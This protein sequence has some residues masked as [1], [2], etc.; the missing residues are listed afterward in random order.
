M[1]PV[2]NVDKPTIMNELISTQRIHRRFSPSPLL[3]KKSPRTLNRGIRIYPG[4]SKGVVYRIS[5]IPVGQVPTPQ[6]G[7]LWKR[8]SLV[9]AG[10]SILTLGGLLFVSFLG[11][12][13]KTAPVKDPLE[14]RAMETY[15]GLGPTANV[16]PDQGDKIPLDL[17][18]TF[19][20]ENY[21]VRKGE[22]ISSIASAHG[23]SLDA[24][25]AL[26]GISNVKN[27]RAGQ[28]IRIP[29]MDGIPYTIKK[30][31]SLFRIS[32]MSGIPLNAI[33]DANDLQSDVL[34]VGMTV[35]L[36]GARMRSDELKRALGQLFIY[37]VRGPLSSL[38][39]W[40]NDPFTGVRRFH[41]AIDIAVPTG[42]PVKAALDGKVSSEGYNGTYGN[43]II[44]SH[45]GG[46]QTL[47]AHLSAF[48][49]PKG[50][51]VSQGQQIGLAGSTGYSTGPH[52][53]FG[54][55][56]NGRS[57]NPLDFLNKR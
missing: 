32:A 42:T 37:P 45:D 24:L 19:S 13:I 17:M 41:A 51:R 43:F 52:V 3:L 21:R 2:L 53:H 9:F 18:E 27:L 6:K 38:Y 12:G 23:L 1:L 30:G 44:L 7:R 57:M 46:Y 55:Y 4:K 16:N 8:V 40:R 47:Y 31:D 26:N 34:P 33:L 10:V 22:T 56:K 20:W 15:S 36:P 54:V 11:S 35:F 5:H 48:S 39:G 28:Q 50:G 14:L 29:N 49:V 25:I